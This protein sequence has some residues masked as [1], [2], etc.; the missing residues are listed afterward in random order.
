MASPECK[1]ITSA[2]VYSQVVEASGGRL[3]PTTGFVG[4]NGEKTKICMMILRIE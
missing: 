4:G 3:D 1:E 2:R